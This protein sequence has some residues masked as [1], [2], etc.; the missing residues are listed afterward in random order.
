M[1]KIRQIVMI[2]LFLVQ[3]ILKILKES[4]DFTQLEECLHNLTQESAGMLLIFALEEIDRRLLAQKEKTLQVVGTRER[5]LVTS[6]GELKLKRRMYKD[7]SGGYIFL[8]DRALGLEPRRRISKRLQQLA[9][10]LGTEMPFRRAA[11]ILGYLA[12]TVSP[13]A[14][15]NTVR[16]AGEE[17][18]SEAL[19]LKEDVFGRGQ[20]SEGQKA[21]DKLFIEG[22]EVW[23]RCQRSNTKG[24]GLKLVV[25][26]EGKSGSRKS[27]KNRHSV[28]GLTDGN[29]IW[30]EASCAF[31]QRWRLSTVEQ[32]CIGG[33]GAA[34]IKK[35][36]EYFPQASYHLD[37][38]HLRKRLT[39]ALS[40]NGKTYEAV[41]EGLARLDRDAVLQALEQGARL[42]RGSRKKKVKDLAHYLM[43]NW[44]GISN[45][46]EGERLGAI[47]GQVRH[48]LA[49]RMKRIGARWTP[50]G[51]DRMGRLLAAKANDEL[52]KYVC[53]T[54]GALC[55]LLESEVVV[56]KQASHREEDLE[57]WLRASMPALKGPFAGKTWIKYVLREIGSIQWSA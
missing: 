4:S 47:E 29:G 49:R 33:D 5:V 12:P 26:Y 22:D 35:G 8:L 24:L 34:W 25:G 17:A 10:E 16:A 48:T 3:G 52:S 2:V 15:W 13:M 21:I 30:E 50:E 6:V 23:V 41:C 43:D 32:V 42:L 14:V 7:D 54:P 11:K 39:E 55:S 36:T 9:L 40:F 37:P 44:Q 56:E 1:L 18:C 51:A 38:F 57:A 45:L 20:V 19:K 28:A 31:A 46:P 27:L 53:R